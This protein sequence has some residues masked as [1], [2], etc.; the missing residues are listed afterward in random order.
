MERAQ[1]YRGCLLGLAVGDAVGTALEFSRPGT[2]EPITDM[3]GGGPFELKPGKWTDDTS[4]ALC[5]A[6][7]LIEKKGFV[8]SDQMERYVRW[9]KEGHL[10]CTGECFDIGNATRNALAGFLRTK[11]PFSGSTDPYTAGNGSIMRL[12]PVPLFYAGQPTYAM[13]FAAESSR[14]THGALTSF[15]RKELPEI[16]GTGYVVRSLEAALWA[17]S[18]SNSFREGCLLAANLG[19]DADTTAAVYGQLAGAFYGEQ[20]IPAEWREKLAMREKIE[21]FA[22]RLLLLSQ[23]IISG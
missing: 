18:K 10:S 20:G 17:F 21:F 19:N 9:W 23:Q 8:P 11:N 16:K 6:E 7:S 3:I 13:E 5:L 2:Y 22:D 1:R 4:M 14:T 15:R 12:A